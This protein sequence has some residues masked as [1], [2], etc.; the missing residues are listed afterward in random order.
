MVCYVIQQFILEIEMRDE[1][2]NAVIVII[3]VS[4]LYLLA[5]NW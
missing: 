3:V 1:S 4:K 2:C 5:I